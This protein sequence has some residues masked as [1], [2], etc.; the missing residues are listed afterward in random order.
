MVQLTRGIAHLTTLL[1]RARRKSARGY[2]YQAMLF[3]AGV[4]WR[5]YEIGLLNQLCRISSISGGSI[6]AA[7]L[8]LAWQKLSFAA[9]DT[10]DFVKLVVEPLRHLAD[11][12]LDA[13]AVL[14]G[15][16]L[17]GTVADNVARSYGEHLFGEATLQSLPDRPRFVFNATN[18]QTGA[19]FRFSKPYMGDYRIGRVLVRELPLRLAVAASSAFPPVLSPLSIELDPASFTPDV[20]ADLQRPPY[21]TRV[22]LT[23]GG[24]YDNLGIETVWKRYDTVFLSDAGG[25]MEPEAEPHSDWVR[26]SYRVLNLVDNQVRSLRKRQVLGSF[27]SGERRGAYWGIRTPID[28]YGEAGQFAAPAER[29]HQL[30]QIATR[31]ARLDPETQKRLINWGYAASDAAL[32]RHFNPALS[33][34]LQ[35]P[36]PATPI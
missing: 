6:T 29:T 2:A 13:D 36:Y 32:R 26:H 35:L 3:H 14:G 24:V 34:S 20:G 11:R 23:D 21:T 15:V 27:I 30:A 9:T 22:V 12:T 31:L 5:L 10:I 16:L 28:E 4:V 8:A 18:V 17:Q 25:K 19:L 1:R 33:R 7:V